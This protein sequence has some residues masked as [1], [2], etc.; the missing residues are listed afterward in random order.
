[1]QVLLAEAVF[2]GKRASRKVV[3]AIVVVCFG[4]GLSTVTD[5]QVYLR[6]TTLSFWLQPTYI[7]TAFLHCTTVQ[8]LYGSNCSTTLFD[9]LL[10]GADGIKSDR[11]GYWRWGSGFY[12]P[13]SNLGRHEAERTGRG[14]HAGMLMTFVDML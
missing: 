5:S 4:V 9:R 6:S 11:M 2:F 8:S 3:A 12:S 14:Q 1:M 7:T 13:V 10:N